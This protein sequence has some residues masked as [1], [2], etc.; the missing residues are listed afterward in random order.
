MN[1]ESDY[2]PTEIYNSHNQ[3]SENRQ[4][5]RNVVDT[6]IP[7]DRP[8]PVIQFERFSY[9]APEKLKIRSPDIGEIGLSQSEIEHAVQYGITMDGKNE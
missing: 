5:L 6:R 1:H 7:A 8:L 3:P 9:T 4:D 2:L